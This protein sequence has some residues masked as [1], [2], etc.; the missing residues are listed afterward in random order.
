[1][2]IIDDLIGASRQA[3]HNALSSSVLVPRGLLVKAAERITELEVLCDLEVR[4]AEDI[5]ESLLAETDQAAHDIVQAL[6]NA[7]MLR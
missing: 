2:N 6:R 5:V 7:G 1:M 3:S 4:T